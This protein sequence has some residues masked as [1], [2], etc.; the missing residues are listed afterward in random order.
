M[1]GNNVPHPDRF[2][3]E[4]IPNEIKK[5][6]G[7]KNITMS[8]YRIQAN[9]LAMCGYVYIGFQEFISFMLKGTSLLDYTDL[10]S[11]NEYEKNDRI[12]LKYFQQL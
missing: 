12:I 5:L 7:N 10:F 11:P 3:V 8:I 4:H 6:I 2:G 9:D 1:N